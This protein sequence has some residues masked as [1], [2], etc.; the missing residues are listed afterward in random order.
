MNVIN[1]NCVET[2]PITPVHGK[3]VF[4]KL[5][6]G[7]KKVGDHL[8]G[9]LSVGRGKGENRGKGSGV[10]KYKLGIRI[11]IGMYK[12]D[13]GRVRIVQEMEKPR[14]LYV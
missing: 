13:R 2:I 10:K 9:G 11:V 1:L 12:I 3:I 4:H 7:A 14:N 8:S 6:P 5:V